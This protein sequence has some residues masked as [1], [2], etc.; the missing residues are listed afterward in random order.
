VAENALLLARL[1]RVLTGTRPDAPLPT[2]L[3]LAYTSMLG[4]DGGSI[5]VGFTPE[6]RSTVSVTDDLAARIEDFQSVLGEGPVLD[7][8]RS[9]AP[10]ALLSR[11][12]Q[13][14]RWPMLL[15]ALH[16]LRHGLILH[17]FPLVRGETII[18]AIT[19]NQV[20]PTPLNYGL[21]EAQFLADAVG[22]AVAGDL[23]DEEAGPASSWS[24]R[25][26]IDQ[27]T[28]MVVAQLSLNPADAVAVLR[29]HAF[30]HDVSLADLAAAVLSREFTFFKDDDE[31][32][33]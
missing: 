6:E 14:R 26:R 4:A 7:A 5:A 29:A 28:G 22:V 11:E 18:G 25:D 33:S 24:V 12:E 9:R 16:E 21:E 1:T 32:E 3:C 2:R 10:V 30:A 15:T 27:A 19:V 17:T 23:T 13:V 20:E 8:Y 31:A